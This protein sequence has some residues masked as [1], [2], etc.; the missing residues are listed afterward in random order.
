MDTAPFITD[1]QEQIII[2]SKRK[3][4][5]FLKNNI[6]PEVSTACP[7]IVLITLSLDEYTILKR[8]ISETYQRN[9]RVQQ[10]EEPIMNDTLIL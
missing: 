1:N 8:L 7:G 4:L 6:T 5:E 2:E 10:Y 9:R 3:M